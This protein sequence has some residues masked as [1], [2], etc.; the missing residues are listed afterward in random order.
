[1]LAVKDGHCRLCW[2]QARRESRL[3]GGLPRGAVSV[4]KAGTLRCHQLFFDRMKGRR[5]EGPARRYDRRGSPRTPPPAPASCPAVRWLQPGLFEGGKDFTRFD[6]DNDADLQNP[7][8][9]WAIYLACR[10]GE[11]RGWKR[12]IRLGV[13][14][15]LIIVLSGH[16]AGDTVCYSGIFPALRARDISAG[17]AA[18]V[19]QEMGV[20]ADDRRPCFEGW[21]DRKPGGLADGIGREAGWWLRTMRDGGPRSRARSIE[22]VR[23]HMNNVR[24]ALLDWSQRYDHLREVTRDDIQAILGGLHGT[25]RSRF[26]VSL[27]SLSAFCKKKGMVVRNPASGIKAGQHPHGI[28][29]PLGQADAGQAAGAAAT[30]SARLVLVLAAVHA[31]RTGAIRAAQPGDADLGNRRLIIAGRVRPIGEFTRQVLPGCRRTR[32][33]DTAHPHLLNGQHP[34]TGTGPVSTI[35][36]AK[37]KLRGQA[38]TPERLRAGRQLEEALARGPDPLHLA[39]V[40]GLDP[41]TAIRYAENARLLL[42]TRAEEQDPARSREPKGQNQP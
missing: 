29:Q 36:Y 23:R 21:L 4:L 5:A 14:R 17:R 42:T 26:L 3:A 6:E 33:P 20:L 15:A 2:Q 10:R 9:I 16:A 37:T 38:A 28:A 27:R 34:A 7:W 30:P 19:L 39:A 13:R 1:V 22:T 40:S 8:L 24:A 25:R 35:Y 41:K 18:G 31:A 12:G 11:A 32:W